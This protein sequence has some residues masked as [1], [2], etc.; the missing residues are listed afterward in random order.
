MN[1]K[2]SGDIIIKGINSVVYKNTMKSLYPRN[3][4]ITETTTTKFNHIVEFNIKENKYRVNYK[5]V[6]IASKDLGTNN[7]IMNIINFKGVQGRKYK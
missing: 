7:L 5:I 4:H 6:D 1:D 3:K 2:E